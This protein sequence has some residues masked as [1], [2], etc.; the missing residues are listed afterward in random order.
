MPI[1]VTNYYKENTNI[2]GAQVA[3]LVEHL[4]LDFGSGHDFTVL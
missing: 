1:R 3:Q 4:I 2:L